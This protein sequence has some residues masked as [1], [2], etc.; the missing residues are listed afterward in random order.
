MSTRKLYRWQKKLLIIVAA[1]PVL[2]ATGCIDFQLSMLSSFVTQSAL[3]SLNL[4]VGSATQ[5]LLQSF[6]SADVLQALLGGNRQPF[7]QG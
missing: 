5:F 2:Q 6:P 7:F 3:S 4:L 1:M